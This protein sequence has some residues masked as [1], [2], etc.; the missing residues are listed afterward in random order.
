MRVCLCVCVCLF[1]CVCVCVFL[2]RSLSLSPPPPSAK[3]GAMELLEFRLPLLRTGALEP[4]RLEPLVLNG[5]LVP[6]ERACVAL[7]RASGVS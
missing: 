7:V 3:H 2:S 5:Q 4:L 6:T 1:V